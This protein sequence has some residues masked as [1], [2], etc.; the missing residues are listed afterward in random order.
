VYID[1]L[2]T[3]KAT[4]NQSLGSI[5]QRPFWF[6]LSTRFYEKIQR[7]AIEFEMTRAKIISEAI[8]IKLVGEQ[9]STPR[10]PAS[11]KGKARDQLIREFLSQAANLRWHPTEQQTGKESGTKTAVNED[12]SRIF[13]VDLPETF[14]RSVRSNATRYGLTEKQFVTKALDRFIEQ[15]RKARRPIPLSDAQEE[16]IK[17]FNR[18]AGKL[19]WKGKD[20]KARKE[21]AR[22]MAKERWKKKNKNTE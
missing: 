19:R 7:A 9:P 12:F 17:E 2:A 18:T 5:P 16:M 20:E 13:W 10:R 11:V 14:Y 15:E 22:L 1:Y 21:H 3:K 8:K 4:S 6:D